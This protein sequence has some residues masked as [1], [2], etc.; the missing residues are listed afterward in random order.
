MPRLLR[1]ALLLLVGLGFVR[2]ERALATIDARLGA[3]VIVAPAG[4]LPTLGG[5]I[6]LVDTPRERGIPRELT[7]RIA[8]MSMATVNKNLIV[9][10]MGH[11]FRRGSSGKSIRR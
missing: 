6:L 2:V 1:L 5:G 9:R 4:A 3:D 7:P 8:G 11:P 10:D